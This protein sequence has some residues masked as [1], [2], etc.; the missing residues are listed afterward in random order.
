M[1]DSDLRA[2]THLFGV[3]YSEPVP[4]TEWRAREKLV[5]EMMKEPLVDKIKNLVYFPK[6]KWDQWF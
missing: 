6:E 5:E 1:K 3:V 2:R 4:L